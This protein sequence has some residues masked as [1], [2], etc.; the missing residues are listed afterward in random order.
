VKSC[1][2]FVGLSSPCAQ[3]ADVE[4]LPVERGV[5]VGWKEIRLR[6]NRFGQHFVDC[7]RRDRPAPRDKWHIDEVVITVR[8]ISHWL[9]R[10]IEADGHVLDILV[11]PL[12]NAKASRRFLRGLIARFEMPR[13]IVTDKLRG[14]IKPI[15]T[16]E[17]GAEHRAQKGLNNAVEVLNRPTTSLYVYL[18]SHEGSLCIRRCVHARR[19]GENCISCRDTLR[20]VGG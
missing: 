11:Q 14:Y 13:V 4:D 3:H 2:C 9:W 1:Q 8:C 19:C 18:A 16:L 5:I 10:V 6:G 15:R 7:V 17:P 20:E 12:R